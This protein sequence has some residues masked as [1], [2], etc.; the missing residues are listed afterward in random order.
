VIACLKELKRVRKSAITLS[1]SLFILAF[2]TAQLPAAE[3]KFIPS[4]GLKEEYNDNLFFNTTT[5]LETSDYITTLSPGAKFTDRTERL[6]ALLQTRL[7]ILRYRDNDE[8]DRY[9]QD[10]LGRIRFRLTERMQASTE[11][12]YIKDSRTDRDIETTG[13]VLG[14]VRRE[15]QH[16]ACSGEDAFTEKTTLGLSYTYDQDKFNDPEYIDSTAQQANLT[17]THNLSSLF[18]MT[19]GRATLGYTL[20][21]FPDTRVNNYSGTI[22]ASTA[23]SE[24]LNLSADVGWRFTR[25]RYETLIWIFPIEETTI[26]RGIIGQAELSF[27]GERTNGSLSFSHDVRSISGRIGAA[28][29]TSLKLEIGRCFTYKLRGDIT[30]EYYLNRAKAGQLSWEDI[31]EETYRIQPRLRYNFTNELALEASYRSTWLKYR[32]MDQKG[33]QG[34]YFLRLSWQ[35]PLPHAGS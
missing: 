22:G 3:I 34:L 14:T 12:G 2:F 18:S 11:A 7:D 6:D 5:E 30:A 33:E 16:Y 31:D 13:A 29:R 23:I 26:S 21:D 9:D 20:Y 32:E 10:H 17:F 8:L 27:R 24:I 4:I 1:L 15:R 35:Y 25:S 19:S 28:K